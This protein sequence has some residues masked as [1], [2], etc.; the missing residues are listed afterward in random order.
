MLCGK[1]MTCNQAEFIRNC[2]PG[3]CCVDLVI[4]DIVV[5]CKYV[6]I[7]LQNEGE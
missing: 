7:I 5:N 2:K 3:I 4:Y 1:L 6:E